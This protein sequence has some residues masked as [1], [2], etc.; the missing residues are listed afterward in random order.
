MYT[1][2]YLAQ[3]MDELDFPA[4]GRVALSADYEKLLASPAVPALLA[5]AGETLFGG[6][7]WRA[8][9]APQLEKAA[10]ASGVHP[11]AVDMLFLLTQSERLRTN[12]AAA[13]VG[14]DVFI[15]SMMDLKYKLLECRRAYGVWGTFVAWWHPWF[16]TMRRFGLGRLQFEAVP[17]P[18]RTPVAVA[19]R[20]V[21]PGDTVYNIHIPSAG[22]LTKQ[23]RLDAY[24][25]AYDFYQ[26]QRPDGW[27][28]FVCH[29]WLLYPPYRQLLAP[30]S[31]IL[32][33]ANDFYIYAVDEVPFAN[34]WRIFGGDFQRPL[35]ALPEETSLQRGFKRWLAEGKPHGNG[36]GLF[37]YDGERFYKE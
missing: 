16:F 1:K 18:G 34:G 3:I 2:A 5:G 10:A 6:G 31:N 8:D 15:N 35:E 12:Y 17:F 28:T 24:R 14:Q 30:T 22:P 11:Y 21:H 4:E 19:G 26:P 13:G 36:A 7:D 23:L 29:S 9:I 32:D 25:W 33:F 20:T 37:L 27:M